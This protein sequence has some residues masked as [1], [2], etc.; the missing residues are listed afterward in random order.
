MIKEIIE[1]NKNFAHEGM[2]AEFATSKYPDKKLAIVTCMDTRLIEMLPAA[3]GIK[4]GDAK[5]I[6]DAGGMIVHPFGA[7][8]RSLLIAI[9]ELGVTDIM[10]IGHTDCGVQHMEVNEFTAKMIEEGIDEEVF[11]QMNYYG[12]DFDKWMGGFDCVETAVKES[13][14]LLEHHPLIPE[15][16]SIYGFIIDTETGLLKQVAGDEI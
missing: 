15:K 10:V 8:V 3:L 2:G 14:E 11:R 9:F 13:V 1:Y 6:K 7:V 5:I 12:I 4:N 16:V